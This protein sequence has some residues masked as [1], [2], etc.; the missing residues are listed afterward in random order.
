MSKTIELAPGTRVSDIQA[1]L[2]KADFIKSFT[3]A[4]SEAGG[5]T[6]NGLK[7]KPFEQVVDSIA[8]NGIRVEFDR[9]YHLDAYKERA[10]QIMEASVHGC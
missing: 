4:C 5:G 7:D 8:R 3:Q 9:S 1:A 2:A 6:W 10:Q